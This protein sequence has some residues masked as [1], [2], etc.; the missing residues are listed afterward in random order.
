MKH[1]DRFFKLDARPKPISADRYERVPAYAA[2]ALFVAAVVAIARGRAEWAHVP[3]LIWL[4]LATILVA[5]GL[6]PVILLRR[7]GDARHRLL[8]RVWVLAML[9][10]AALTLGIRVIRPGH[11]S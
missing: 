3:A 4:H 11:W 7:R 8:G 9:A 1:G 10:S 5:T 2:A 6:T